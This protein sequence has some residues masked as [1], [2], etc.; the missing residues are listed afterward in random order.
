MIIQFSISAKCI[1]LFH[2][3]LSVPLFPDNAREH[4]RYLLLSVISDTRTQLDKYTPCISCTHTL[5][6]HAYTEIAQE[7]LLLH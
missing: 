7:I 4:C 6:T 2:L 1:H 3:F 5:C